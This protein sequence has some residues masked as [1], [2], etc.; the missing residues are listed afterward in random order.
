MRISMPN[1]Y[2]AI[3]S[4]KNKDWPIVIYKTKGLMSL[5]TFFILT[6]KISNDAKKQKKNKQKTVLIQRISFK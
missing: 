6:N 3:I 5:A 4:L 1:F 2:L